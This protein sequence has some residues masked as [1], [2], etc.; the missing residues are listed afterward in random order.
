CVALVLAG[1]VGSRL[2]GEI[3]KQYLDLSGRA[4]L[5][6]SVQT[7]LDHPA[8]DEV[9]CVIR[10]EDQKLYKSAVGGLPILKPVT[11][12]ENR[13]ESTRLGLESLAK[14]SPETVL[15][16]DAAR[17][18]VDFATIN[19]TLAGLLDHAAALPAVPLS[20]T[21]K[22]SDGLRVVDTI[23]RDGL[24]RAQTP[25]GFRYQQ[26]LAAHQAMAGEALTDDATVAARAGLEITL[27]MGSENNMK[28]TT[29]DDLQR[30]RRMLVGNAFDV[31]VGIGFDVH[32]F[33]LGNEIMLCGIAVPSD[34]GLE[35]HSDADVGLHAVTDALLGAVAA[36][37][38]GT[39]FSPSDSQWCDTPSDV[40]VRHAA[41]FV[42][43]KDGEI[44][45]IDITII[46]E[47]PKITPHRAAMMVRIAKILDIGDDR[48]NV[49]ATTTEGLG[50]TGRGDG[51]AVQALATVRLPPG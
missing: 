6:H 51:I 28:I 5:C 24:W 48:V 32:R 18:F 26:I 3:P 43:S 20:D 23:E 41:D 46:C 17:P 16:H 14:T 7:F 1:G 42:R 38:I 25:Q 13:Q 40:F 29:A 35:G 31:R 33:G 30:A 36:G 4:L 47:H 11:G 19:R 34:R 50:F 44:S 49:K 8:I 39:H 22:R 37:D 10:S 2:G 45:H 15:I 21:L 27:V 9:R 12:G